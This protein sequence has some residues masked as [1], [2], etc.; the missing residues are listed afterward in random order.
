MLPGLKPGQIVIASSL[1]RSIKPNSVVI[2]K[3]DRIEKIK[4]VT[5][6]SDHK[7]FVLGDNSRDSLDS[8]SFGWLSQKNIVAKV[9][10]PR[11]N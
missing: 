8:R 3:H 11:L 9:Y 5:K 6:V 10:W 2:I 1:Y 4:R 7:V